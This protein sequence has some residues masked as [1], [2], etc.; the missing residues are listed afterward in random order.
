MIAAQINTTHNNKTP[1]IHLATKGI[2]FYCN[3]DVAITAHWLSLFYHFA[4]LFQNSPVHVSKFVAP[5]KKLVAT[6]NI[7]H[8]V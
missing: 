8:G 2:L 1:E 3:S 6:V 5:K 4:D 7:D